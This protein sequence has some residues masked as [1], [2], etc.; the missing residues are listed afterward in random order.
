MRGQQTLNSNPTPRCRLLKF[1]PFWWRHWVKMPQKSTYFL[2]SLF[3]A[4][5]CPIV[6]L[7]KF[8][9]QW[10]VNHLSTP[11]QLRDIDF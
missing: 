10:G 3:D 4:V 11:T 7:I 8:P 2:T 5:M 1:D 6:L 9:F